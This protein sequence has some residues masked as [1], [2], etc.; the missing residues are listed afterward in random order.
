M[1]PLTQQEKQVLESSGS[2]DPVR[3]R[4]VLLEPAHGDT[5]AWSRLG[6][7]GE[8]I[9]KEA[10]KQNG[11]DRDRMD[12]RQRQDFVEGFLDGHGR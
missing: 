5:N 1:V 9:L 2:L 12:D 8:S 3:R 7:Q 11:L 10:A 4:C 6:L